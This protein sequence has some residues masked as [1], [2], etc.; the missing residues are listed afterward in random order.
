ME[1]GMGLHGEQGAFTQPLQSASA[2]A[3]QVRHAVRLSMC[4]LVFLLEMQAWS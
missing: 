2:T 4:R 1:V 3:A